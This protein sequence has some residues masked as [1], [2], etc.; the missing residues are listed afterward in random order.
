MRTTEEVTTELYSIST[1]LNIDRLEEQGSSK[2]ERRLLL[3]AGF[4]IKK[5]HLSIG[6]SKEMIEEM[7]PCYDFFEQRGKYIKTS[8]WFLTNYFGL[9]QFEKVQLLIQALHRANELNDCAEIILAKLPWWHE[10]SLND[11]TLIEPWVLTATR[12]RRWGWLFEKT[13]IDDPFFEDLVF[14]EECTSDF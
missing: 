2:E 1:F 5:H 7:K 3:Q 14:P 9:Q 8:I 11:L 12:S 6:L 4:A 13:N 10:G